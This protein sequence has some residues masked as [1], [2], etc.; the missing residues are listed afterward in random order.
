M[1]RRVPDRD[2]MLQVFLA[3]ARGSSRNGDLLCDTI[4]VMLRMQA[5]SG[6]RTMDNALVETLRASTE[7]L[8]EAGVTYAITGSIASSRHGEPVSSLDVDLIVSA[9][10]EQ[11]VSVAR[12]LSPRFYAPEEMLQAS[13]RAQGFAN[14]I[15]N[16]TSFKVDLSFVEAT[17]FLSEVLQRRIRATIGTKSPE[18]WFVTPEDIILMKLLWR[19]NTRSTKQWENA[20]SVARVKGA[21][22]DWKYLFEQAGTLDIEA[23]L[24]ALRDEAGI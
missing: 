3:Q 14:L 24:V 13:S 5:E 6:G 1:T 9:T 22:M 17:G 4:D 11:A 18:F 7:A 12:K 8:E 10:P 19:K 15:D 21:R 20:L 2:R 23:D 16:Q